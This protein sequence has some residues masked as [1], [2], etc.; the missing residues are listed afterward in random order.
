MA[1]LYGAFVVSRRALDG[2]KRRFPARAV[3]RQ[4]ILQVAAVD[5]VRIMDADSGGPRPPSANFHSQTP[6]LTPDKERAI[7][8]APVLLLQTLCQ[9]PVP[10]G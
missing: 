3:A 1:L 10:P 2:P 5:A 9:T 4:I 6:D 8:S 7:E